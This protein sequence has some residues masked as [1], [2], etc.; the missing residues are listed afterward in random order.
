MT[1][2]TQRRQ[3]RGGPYPAEVAD[4]RPEYATIRADSARA[5]EY[6]RLWHESV[7]TRDDTIRDAWAAGCTI[8][9]I[10]R[11]AGLSY[12]QACR[13]LGAYGIK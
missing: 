12:Q 11:A 4:P 2:A 7:A 1:P 5:R 9:A 8:P 6:R 13:I 3:Y 10:A